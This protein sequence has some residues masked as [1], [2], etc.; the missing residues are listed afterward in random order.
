MTTGDFA[1]G[2][3]M[4]VATIALVGATFMLVIVTWQL[5]KS[6]ER[7]TAIL[8]ENQRMAVSRDQPK[9]LLKQY[10]YSITTATGGQK[11][12]DGFTVANAGAVDVTI[13]GVGASFA[14]PVDN[15]DDRSIPSLSLAPKEWNGSNI[16]G[17]DLPVKLEP[18]DIARFLFDSNDLEEINRPY[19]WRCQDSL[20][21]VYKVEGWLRRSQNTLTYMELGDEFIA[22]NPRFQMW[23]R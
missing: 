17:D 9:L 3:G 19:Q 15:P 16:R 14:I 1:V 18:G 23:A 20:G 11:D 10:G 12:F 13:T 22:P 2:L 5:S 4:V 21:T 7:Q 8:L 6:A